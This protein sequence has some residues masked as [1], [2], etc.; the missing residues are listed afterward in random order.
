MFLDRKIHRKTPVPVSSLI[1]LQASACNFIKKRLWPRCFP[2][3]FAWFLRTPIL[4][5]T[6]ERLLLILGWHSYS[7]SYFPAFGLNTER[8]CVSLRI[9]SEW[10][11]IWTWITPNL[12]FFFTQCDYFSCCMEM[13]WNVH[14]IA[15]NSNQYFVQKNI[16]YVLTVSKE[17]EKK[18]N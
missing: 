17:T 14:R 18:T 15:D 5:N 7:G 12:E 1:K 6:T 2:M 16:K 13:I 8:Y 4:Q 9:Q 3:N 11:K 10:W